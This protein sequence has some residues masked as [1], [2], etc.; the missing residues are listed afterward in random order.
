MAM[1]GPETRLGQVRHV[2]EFIPPMTLR[3]MYGVTMHV[4]GRCFKKLGDD[5]FNGQPGQ[6]LTSVPHGVRCGF[7]GRMAYP[8]D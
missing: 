4:C 5:P 2:F 7:C 8:T 6:I 1:Q 3:D